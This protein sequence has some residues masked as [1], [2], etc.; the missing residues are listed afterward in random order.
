MG[1]ERDILLVE[2]V[3]ERVDRKRRGS[4][5]SRPGWTT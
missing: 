2:R 5:R 1:R 3:S 4:D